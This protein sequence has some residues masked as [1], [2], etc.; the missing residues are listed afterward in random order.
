MAITKE[1]TEE[2][3]IGDLQEA[4]HLLKETARTSRS[5]GSITAQTF[6]AAAT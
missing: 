2:I 4:Q 6:P 5:S 1:R 3:V